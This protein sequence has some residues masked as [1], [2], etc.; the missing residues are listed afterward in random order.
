MLA[1]VPEV[2]DLGLGRE[3]FEEG[4]VVGGPVGDGADPDLRAH[5]ADMG[6]LACK[7]RFQRGLAALGHT[8][9]IEG[10]QPL[11]LGV[12]EGDRAAR[13]LAPARLGTAVLAGPQRHHDAVKGD[14]RGDRIGRYALGF[15]DAGQRLRG[16]AL[17][18][19]MHAQGQALQRAHR[20][21][22]SAHFR[23]ELLRFTR[24]TV[25]HHHQP[26]LRRRPRQVVVD[27]AQALVH[28]HQRR[29]ARAA[30]IARTPIGHGTERRHDRL[31]RRR[32]PDPAL[33]VALDPARTVVA[34]LGEGPKELAT[35]AVHGVPQPRLNRFERLGR[36]VRPSLFATE[37]HHLGDRF[38]DFGRQAQKVDGRGDERLRHW[39]GNAPDVGS[40]VGLS[41]RHPT[42]S[43][44]A[45]RSHPPL[46]DAAVV[47]KSGP[48]P[49]DCHENPILAAYGHP[50]IALNQ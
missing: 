12:V 45:E 14:G 21:R 49:A 8:A 34:A 50:P 23:E 25:A 26:E 35:Q 20:R 5:T 47:T 15:T 11:A 4:P 7:L 28:R 31:R 18:V 46:L 1:S 16:D 2:D 44:G 10:L 6:D 40:D 3:A 39:H 32:H 36:R 42:A 37:L 19:L 43:R 24:R 17:P 33:S 41:A 29:A 48:A 38:G 27:E 9:E 22:H 30:A 13:G